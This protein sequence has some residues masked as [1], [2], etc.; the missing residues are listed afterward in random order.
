M[1][2]LPSPEPTVSCFDDL[3]F[4]NDLENE[5][6]SIVYNDAQ[7]S[8][9][10]DL[11]Y[12]KDFEK[13]FPAI[14]YNDAQTSKLDFSTEPVVIPQH[15]DEFYLKDETSFSKCDEEEQNVLNFND[16]FPFNVIYPNDSKSDKDND[17]DKVDIE[18]SSGELSIKPLPDI[19]NVNDGAYAHGPVV[20][21]APRQWNAKLTT[22]L[23]EHGFEQRKF[24]YSLYVKKKGTMFVSLFVNVYDIFITGNN[25]VEIKSFKKFLSSK[26]LIKDLGELKYFLGIE[27]LKNDKDLC[28]TQRKYC[29]ELLHEYG[30]LAA[31]PMDILFLPYIS[32][33]VHCLSQHMHSP[34]QTHFKVALRV[35]RYLTGSPS[36][37][38]QFNKCSDLKLKAY[39]D[40][41][42][43]KCHKTR[44][45]VTG[46]C[47]FLGNSLIS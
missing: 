39:A 22:A 1:T 6:P 12:F 11:G 27:V 45:T 41:D 44:K 9:L 3:D 26:F 20:K 34:L 28:M 38:L 8:K 10:Y 2:S 36:L 31:K 5:F 16:L 30:L 40:A 17:D 14:I 43:T 29:L 7:T 15:I 13:E 21:M 42:W 23:I 18:H 19:I 33:V 35:L 37:G 24:D 32:Y 46:Y 47:V 4:F 25:E